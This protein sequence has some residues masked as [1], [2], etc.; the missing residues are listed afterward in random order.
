MLGTQF[1]APRNIT[2]IYVGVLVKAFIS[3][4]KEKLLWINRTKHSKYFM[5]YSIWLIT[6]WEKN[7]G[8][9][10]LVCATRTIDLSSR[11]LS[12]LMEEYS[13]L[14]GQVGGRKDLV[15]VTS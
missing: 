2:I 9:H 12:F 7:A 6:E 8:W 1:S 4:Y 5:K 15:K 10:E 13:V 14:T 3:R 11:E